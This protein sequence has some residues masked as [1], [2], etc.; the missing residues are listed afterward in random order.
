MDKEA[1]IELFK[2]MTLDEQNKVIE[3]LKKIKKK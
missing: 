3:E 1:F 2:H